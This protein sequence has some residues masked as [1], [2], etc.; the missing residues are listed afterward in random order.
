MKMSQVP[1]SIA[2]SKYTEY[3]LKSSRVFVVENMRIRQYNSRDLK[4]L[5]YV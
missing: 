5:R 3:N 1:V 4:C 2:A